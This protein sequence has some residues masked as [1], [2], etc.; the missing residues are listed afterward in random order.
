MYRVYILAF[1]FALHI[2]L[3]AYVNSTFIAESVGEKYVGIMYTVAALVTLLLLSNTSVILKYFGNRRLA[4]IFVIINMLSLA[5]FI[6]TTNPLYV[7]VAFILFLATNV[8]VFFCIDIFIE[9]FG[10]P[11]T[12]GRTRGVYLTIVN[13][14]WVIS[15]LLSGFLI[16][17][18]GG[19]VAIYALTFIMTAC[20]A[21]GLIFSVKKFSD[22]SYVKTP[23]LK[24]Y[25]FLKTNR[26][27]LS[28][29]LINFILQFFFALMVIYTPIYL[30]QHIGLAWDK[31]G[32][33]FTIMLAPFVLLSI[34]LGKLIDTY[35]VRK[36]VLLTIGFCIISL[37]TI[38]ISGIG[39]KSIIVWGII[40]FATRVGACIAQTV[41]EIYFFTHVREEDAYLLSVFRDM[42]PVA[43]II[44]PLLGTLF[45]YYFPFKYLFVTLGV[46][47][48]SGLYYIAHLK[49]NHGITIPDQNQ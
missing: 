23:F 34:P 32:I 48:L 11:N 6:I 27:L 35:H 17:R 4:L 42:E 20:M 14:A 16:T 44:A 33:I 12:V 37:S 7:G 18:G 13:F 28:I 41:S 19:Y 31:I 8:L 9:H 43:Y 45:L 15:P 40:L 36:R 2:A 29:T 49:H 39:T 3:S 1:I 46:F 22:R 30:H 26:H 24:A 21:L 38:A 10:T 5:T 25:K 47:T